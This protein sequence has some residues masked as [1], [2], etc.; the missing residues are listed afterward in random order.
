MVAWKIGKVH[1][2]DSDKGT[3]IIMCGE[4]K[5]FYYV[6]Y[7]AII[8]DTDFKNLN[9]NGDVRFKTYKNAYSE[10]VSEVEQYVV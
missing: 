5:E 4:N 1:Y 8:S 2:W 9:T 7:S 3:G 6:H 10:K